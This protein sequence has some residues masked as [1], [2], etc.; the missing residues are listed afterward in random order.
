MTTPT[1]EPTGQVQ[2]AQADLDNFA[3]EINAAVAVLA[4]YI[5][6]LLA[7]QTVQLEAAD[8]TKVQG[9]ITA[10][11]NLEPPAPTPPAS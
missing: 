2:I 10:L 8:E 4:P 9:A 5:Q 7:G 1:P 3:S 11:T 6:Q